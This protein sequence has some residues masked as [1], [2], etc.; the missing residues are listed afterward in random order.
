MGLILGNR[1]GFLNEEPCFWQLLSRFIIIGEKVVYFD[2]LLTPLQY[3]TDVCATVVATS[4]IWP[5]LYA[6][7]YSLSNMKLCGFYDCNTL[8]GIIYSGGSP[9]IVCFFLFYIF[10][11][12]ILLP[13]LQ[14]TY[15]RY[16]GGVCG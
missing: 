6:V 4:L 8:F 2:F 9:V 15:E 16:E 10:T 12:S 11:P 1:Y 14:G 5:S 3:H 13:F 7:N